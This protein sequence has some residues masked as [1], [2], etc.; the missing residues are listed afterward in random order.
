MKRRTAITSPAGLPEGYREFIISLKD[1]IRAA[2]VKAALSVNRELVLLSWEI[3]N[4]IL[5]R[6]EKEGWGAKVIERLSSDLM[7]EF[8]GMKGSLAEPTM[9]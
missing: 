4:D 1:R 5:T 2:Q 7:H 9:Q 8:P 6:Q 3:G